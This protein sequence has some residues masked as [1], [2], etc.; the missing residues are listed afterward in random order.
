[1]GDAATLAWRLLRQ[2]SQR[3]ADCWQ[4]SGPALPGA[5]LFLGPFR[6]RSDEPAAPAPTTRSD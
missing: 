5:Q 6:S 4:C 1:M 2:A 3:I